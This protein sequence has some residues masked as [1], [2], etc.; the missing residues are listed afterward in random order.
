[1]SDQSSKSTDSWS[2]RQ[3]PAKSK[4]LVK[5]LE[6]ASEH[7]VIMVL[8][9]P[10]ESNDFDM[11]GFNPDNIQSEIHESDLEKI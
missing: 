3:E 1:M 7:E 11:E 4:V 9:I 10:L 5:I 8:E 2:S 6:V